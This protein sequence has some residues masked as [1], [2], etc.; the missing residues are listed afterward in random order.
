MVIVRS[1]VAV[2]G[3]LSFAWRVKAHVCTA[4][5]VPD[6]VPVAGSIAMPGHNTPALTLHATGGVQS[7][8]V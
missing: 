7:A 6:I 2:L 1:S 5:A 4:D 8:V 3:V